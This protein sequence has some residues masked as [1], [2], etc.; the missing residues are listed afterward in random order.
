MRQWCRLNVQDPN[1]CLQKGHWTTDS[2]SS[3]VTTDCSS[4]LRVS[5]CP[6]RDDTGPSKD[7]FDALVFSGEF[8]NN[9]VSLVNRFS[10]LDTSRVCRSTF[11]RRIPEIMLMWSMD[12][13]V[14]SL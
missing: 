14:W 3:Q 8:A 1:S 2:S 9:L 12:T 11:F 4:S 5:F 7:P 6:I 13:P 10:S